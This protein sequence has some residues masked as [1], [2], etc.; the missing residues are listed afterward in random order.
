MPK[1]SIIAN[2]FTI[3]WPAISG[4]EPCIGSNIPV[5]LDSEADGNSPIEPVN[6]DAASDKISPNKLGVKITSNCLGF[7]ITCIAALSTYICCRS[8][9]LCFIIILSTVCRHN[10]EHSKTLALSIDVICFFLFLAVSI[11]K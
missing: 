11:A 5:S 8:I 6:I 1:D 9:S 10:C 7:F 4:A 3:P 2:G